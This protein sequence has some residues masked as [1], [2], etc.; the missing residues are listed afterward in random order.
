[1]TR[2]L[3]RKTL[4][5]P[6]LL[7]LVRGCF[8]RVPDPVAGRGLTLPDCLMSA[9]A[10]FGLKYAS[11]LQFDRDARRDERVRSNL[12]SLYGVGRA[13]SD[14]AMR[15]RLDAVDPALLRGAFKRVWAALQRGK[16]LADFTWLG[17]HVLSVDG[18]GFHS[19][20]SV[21]CERCCEKRRRDG[22]VT[23]YHQM[24]AAVLVH[25]AHR[26][27]F[28]LAPEPI[29]K[30]DGSA[31]ND[32]EHNAAKRLLAHARREHPH[33]KLLVVQD[34][35]AANGPHIALL[36]S[37]DMRFVL[38]VKPD[39]HRHLFEWVEAT[40]GVRTFETTDGKGVTRRYRYLNGAPLN[41][42][43]FDLEVNFLECRESRPGK[44]HLA[45]VFANLMMLAFLI[46]QAQQRC[47]G[48]FRAAREKAGRSKYL[49]ERLRGL[50][51]EFFVPD[52][53]TLYRAI[54]FGHRT[55][56]VPFD[57]S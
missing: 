10:L 28:P 20:E 51:L 57:T 3:F 19:S 37:L 5:A 8:E 32:S 27:V 35:L 22:T 18:T 40:R 29:E 44:K 55:E 24:V 9:L 42:A 6:G 43:H 7:G 17:Y 36:R 50:F 13:P 45:T 54:A 11:L 41:G 48:L 12:R 47:C 52:W 14:T 49:W 23:Y 34:A 15:E 33:L 21:R 53:E 4:S 16:A 38:G 1:M 39:G 30:A 46:D 26:E 25:P 31:K 2:S 56:L